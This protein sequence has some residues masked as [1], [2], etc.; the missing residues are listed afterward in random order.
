MKN[1]GTTTHYPNE[2]SN[3]TRGKSC[4]EHQYPT[5]LTEKTQNYQIQVLPAT[6]QTTTRQV[7]RSLLN[8]I[9]SSPRRNQFLLDANSQDRPA[10]LC[11]LCC[12]LYLRTMGALNRETGLVFDPALDECTVKGLSIVTWIKAS[13]C[14][15]H[16][17]SGD[18]PLVVFVSMPGSCMQLLS[19]NS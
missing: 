19:L 4:G 18:I 9:S 2:D 16:D 15:C 13:H 6:R 11:A 17:A 3:A 12:C 10:L 8:D 14:G 7:A 1:R 5:G